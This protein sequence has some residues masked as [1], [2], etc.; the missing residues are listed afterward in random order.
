MPKNMRKNR[1]KYAQKYA[2]KPKIC[3][4]ICCLA[5]FIAFLLPNFLVILRKKRQKNSK[6]FWLPEKF[7]SK[8]WGSRKKISK[9]L[10]GQKNEP[11]EEKS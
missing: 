11:K 8:N 4:K 1:P 10:A 7:F 9:K 3:G 6:K 5:R 2:Q